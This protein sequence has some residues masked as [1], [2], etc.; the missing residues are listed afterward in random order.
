MK[1][2]V[3]GADMW[4]QCLE[5]NIWTS[6]ATGSVSSAN[7]HNKFVKNIKFVKMAHYEFSQRTLYTLEYEE[8]LKASIQL[9]KILRTLQTL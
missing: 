8:I 5:I 1:M 3:P 2:M 4:G 9:F 7:S 6:A